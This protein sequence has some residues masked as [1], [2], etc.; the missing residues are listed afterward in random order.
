MRVVL[1][2][3]AR[4]L[5][6]WKKRYSSSG[7]DDENANY[8]RAPVESLP[9]IDM[10]IR[11]VYV[12]TL[13]RSAATAAFLVGEKDI[14]TTSLLDEVPIRS[15]KDSERHLPTWLWNV[16]ATLQW[17][18]GSPRQRETRKETQRKID[19]FLD[20]IEARGEDCIVVGHGI[21]FYDM[22]KRMKARGYGGKIKKYMRNGEYREFV[23]AAGSRKT[24]GEKR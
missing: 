3:H 10:A 17:H 18:A 23:A 13:P 12:S 22:M 11:K 2:R 1:L 24:T 4:V 6:A 20:L 9:P 8:D 15:F 16:M 5:V 7:Y 14:E 19:A 21:H